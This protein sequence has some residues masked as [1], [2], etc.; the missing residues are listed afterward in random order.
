MTLMCWERICLHKNSLFI[1]E[2]SLNDT[3]IKFWEQNLII[4]YFYLKW[5]Y[6]N[7]IFTLCQSSWWS[8]QGIL[9]EQV[10][11]TFDKREALGIL[12]HYE[13]LTDVCIWN[14]SI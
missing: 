9:H 11:V 8:G 6:Y 10:S 3:D 7:R 13:I 5:I 1:T 4:N 2:Y 12:M 14:K